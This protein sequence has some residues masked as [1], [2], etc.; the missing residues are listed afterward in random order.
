MVVSAE[1]RAVREP[2]ASPGRSRRCE[3]RRSSARATGESREGGGRGSPKSED[4]PVA[5][6]EPLAEGG[7]VFRRSLVLF[8]ALAAVLVLAPVVFAARVHVRVEGKTQTI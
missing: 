5:E 7:F 6:I 4:L 1:R 8:A 3:G 2:G